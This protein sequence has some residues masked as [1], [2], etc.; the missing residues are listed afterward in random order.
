MTLDDLIMA[1]DDLSGADIKVR[2]WAG[3]APVSRVPRSR[4]PGVAAV[5]GHSLLPAGRTV[6]L[7]PVTLGCV[8][9]LWN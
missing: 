5:T 8:W 1:K 3:L 6:A 4:E 2:G 9:H 7:L